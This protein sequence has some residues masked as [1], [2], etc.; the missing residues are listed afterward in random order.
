MAIKSR[1][2]NSILNILTG[3][4][5]YVINA[6]LGFVCRIVFIRCLTAEYL[7]ISGLF[8]NILTMLSLAE[9][10][11][12]NAIVFALYKPL[13]TNDE[14]KIASLMRFYAKAYR[15]I[16]IVV[17]I[18]GLCMIPF[19]GVVI[20]DPPHIKENLYIIYLIYLFN[21]SSSYFFSY[22]SSLIMADQQNYIVT[23]LNYIITILQ[24]IIQMIYLF[25]TKEYM[26]YLI[27]QTIGTFSFN[28]II[29]HIADK[30]YL[31]IKGKNIN[32]LTKGESKE[33]TGNIKALTI[34]KLSGLL[35]NNTDN[36][37][38]TYFNGLATVGLVSNYT[39][40]STTLN[41]LLNQIFNGIGA[42][43]GNY[44]AIESKEKKLD[45]FNFINS[46]NFWLF[47]WATIGIVVLSSD[48]VGICFGM[49]YILPFNI[50]CIIALNFYM[51]GMQSAVWTYKNAMGL[52]IQGR[53]LLIV[54]AILNLVLSIIL[55]DMLG[56]FGIL[57][58]TTI[59]RLL[60]N[61]WYD[62]YAVYK[63]GLKENPKQYF[64]K[65]ISLFLLMIIT[66]LGTL[67]LCSFINSTGILKV[68]IKT[69]ICIVFPNTVFLMYF[70]RKKEFSYF[71]DVIKRMI[72]LFLRSR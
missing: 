52:F 17:A 30:K 6:V 34:W 14:S 50:P 66:L 22:K 24:S 70:Y 29:S 35:V 27:I 37:I 23:G 58:A 1:T 12:G 4:G 21:T 31:Y 61:T 46:T 49:D 55:G 38:I 9:L 8:T 71:K 15:I 44:N 5:G 67:F 7:G 39:L 69:I 26:G 13:A 54:T 42:S 3:L 59:S 11:I 53:Y 64:K 32:P 33:L 57:L 56:L 16:G 60:T 51:I 43:V 19:L 63:Y 72:K 36:I 45:M 40:L 25:A 68:I 48:I 65:Y 62:P 2:Q 10:G 41:T 20:K 28:F 18:F 47:G